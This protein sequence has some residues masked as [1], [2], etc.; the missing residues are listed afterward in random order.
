MMLRNQT[1]SFEFLPGQL[2]NIK[3][4]GRQNATYVPAYIIRNSERVPYSSAVCAF[5]LLTTQRY[6]ITQIPLGSICLFLFSDNK[7]SFV[8]YGE[9]IVEV[10]PFWLEPI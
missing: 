2:V 7:S 6:D 8:L 4:S 5:P 1:K 3:G 10:S 9:R